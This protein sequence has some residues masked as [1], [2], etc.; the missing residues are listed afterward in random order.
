MLTIQVLFNI[1]TSAI[2]LQDFTGLN[3]FP[4]SQGEFLDVNKDILAIQPAT[5]ELK[6]ETA[7][8]NFTDSRFL[9]TNGDYFIA[10]QIVTGYNISNKNFRRSLVK[11]DNLASLNGKK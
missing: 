11:F 1:T 6:L 7:V 5:G 10:D 2:Y 9:F 3:Y 8:L 4:K